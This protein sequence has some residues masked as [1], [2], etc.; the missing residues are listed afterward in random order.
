LS[1]S[2]ESRPTIVDPAHE[3]DVVDHV[4]GS[5]HFR[6]SCRL[7]RASAGPNS[8]A[9]RPSNK[10]ATLASNT[11]RVLCPFHQQQEQVVLRIEEQQTRP[12]TL[13]ATAMRRSASQASS[14]SS[15]AVL[16][17]DESAEGVR[18]QRSRS[19]DA[20]LLAP[21]ATEKPRCKLFKRHSSS[22]STQARRSSAASDERPQI[23]SRST[24]QSEDIPGSYER[25]RT[26][27]PKLFKSGKPSNKA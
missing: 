22:A 4:D 25:K 23:P 26:R 14:G 7:C 2:S 16:L 21:A 6:P 9:K 10:L 18:E 1:E 8:T 19:I 15:S 27:L 24:T 12:Q 20:I 13:A 17:D 3:H 11:R 5:T